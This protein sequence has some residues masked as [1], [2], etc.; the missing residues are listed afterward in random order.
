MACLT[1]CLRPL[2]LRVGVDVIVSEQGNQLLSAVVPSH[3]GAAR[4]GA[5]EQGSITFYSAR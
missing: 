3:L 5:D 2:D 1:R 4:N